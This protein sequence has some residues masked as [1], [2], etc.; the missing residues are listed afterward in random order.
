[1]ALPILY[2]VLPCYNEEDVLR[3][4]GEILEKK[5][6]SLIQEKKIHKQSKILFVNDGSRDK[7][8]E[9]IKEFY[10][11]NPMF[12]GLNLSRNRGH[13]NAV[14]AGLMTAR[15]KA[16][17]VISIDADLQQDIN[18]I[19]EMLEKYAQGVEVVY[20]IRNDRGTDSA[21]KKYTALAFYRL[22]NIMGCEV[23]KNHADYRMMSKRVIDALSE[24]GE[25]NLFLRGLVPTIGFTS[26]VVYFD[27]KER[28]AGTS[29]YTMGKMLSFALDGITSFSIRPLQ[30]ISLLGAIMLAISMAMILITF[31]EYFV[32]K[33]LPGFASTYI[34]A[35]FIG[36]IQMLSLGIIGEYV[37]K[38]YME[39]K[40]R[41][42][43]HIEAF[44]WKEE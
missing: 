29:K 18:A 2:L 3:S 1:M 7:T 12:C 22:M 9:I 19:D 13:Q 28:T 21:V 41:P 25:V 32:G 43:Y 31:Y 40:K 11:K 36:S 38:I 24:Y 16:D 44:L 10:S 5:Y 33:T 14:L 20:G 42:R 17:V 35:W 6:N 26:D 39:T 27:V 15:E 8:W 30:L 4:T 37:G 23:I 34:A